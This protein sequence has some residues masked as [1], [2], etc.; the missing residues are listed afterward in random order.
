[1]SETVRTWM[2][3]LKHRGTPMSARPRRF[4]A[5]SGSPC[6]GASSSGPSTQSGTFREAGTIPP[7]GREGLLGGGPAQDR[8]PRGAPRPRPREPAWGSRRS[9]H[10]LSGR[11]PS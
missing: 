9:A 6:P 10:A 8:T 1:M 3:G 4:W 5:S 11:R 2:A 7:L